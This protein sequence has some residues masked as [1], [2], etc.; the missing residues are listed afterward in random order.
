MT[1]AAEHKQFCIEARAQYL[2]DRDADSDRQDWKSALW[3]ARRL[4]INFLRAS[5][6]LTNVEGALK[7][8]GYHAIAL[9]HFLAPPISQDQ[10]K[11]I[12]PDWSKSS[13]KTGRPLSLAAASAVADVFEERRARRLSP[14]LNGNRNPTLNELSG[15]IGSIA[16]LIASQRVSTARRNR[17]AFRQESLVISLLEARN[18]NRLQS[19]LVS[20]SGQLPAKTFMHK[21]RFASG[22]NENQE[23]DIACG[24]GGTVVLAMECKVTNDETNSVKRINDVLKKASAWKDFWGVFVK[25]AAVLQGVIKYADVQRLLDANVEVFWAQRLDLFSDWLDSNE[26]SV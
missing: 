20:T 7:I 25:P 22:P 4:I 8:S 3:D 23:V 18:W 11:L 12:C 24:L 26:Q 19:G 13:E 1:S 21:T 9:R 14:W 16:P 6:F 5:H 17:R 15:T 2:L 10:F